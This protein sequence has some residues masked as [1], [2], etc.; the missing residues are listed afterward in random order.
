MPLADIITWTFAAIAVVAFGFVVRNYTKGLAGSPRELWLLYAYKLTETT[1]YALALPTLILSLKKDSG[2]GDMSASNYMFAYSI[3]ISVFSIGMGAFTDTV[4]I[5]KMTLAS[6][7][8][9]FIARLSLGTIDNPWVLFVMAYLPM[10]IGMAVVAPV[11]SVGVKKFTTKESSSLGF[12]LYYIIMNLGF[13]IGGWLF[14]KMRTVLGERDAAGKMVN[15]NA[16]LDLFGTHFST[17]KI[18]FLASIV[19]T[20]LSLFT[21]LA[22]RH[23]V[24]GGTLNEKPADD[25][26]G[27]ASVKGAFLATW[28]KLYT[29]ARERYFWIFVGLVGIILF[30]QAVNRH[31]SLTFPDYGIRVLGE[32]A[33]IGSVYGVLNP[34]LIIFLVPVVA[35]LTKKVPSYRLITIGSIVS[36]VACFLAAIPGH[37]F[38][39]LTHTTLGEIVFVNW[40]GLAPD[41][42]ALAANPPSPVYWP[43][44]LFITI[45]TI[46]EAIWSPRFYQFTAE[47]A[48][49]GKEATYLSLAVLPTFA[50]KFIVAAMSGVLLNTYVPVDA[51]KKVLPHDNHFMVWVWIGVSAAVTPIGLLLC[52]KR[53]HSETDRARREGAAV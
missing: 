36:T 9:L 48:P 52:S 43:L 44:M 15:E 28:D 24:A 26:E 25:G 8:A 45:F 12:A 22:M 47:I 3:I 6:I 46:G 49:K 17:Y 37:C 19:G 23:S 14:D 41:A 51:A 21:I 18:I 35:A 40:L 27:D 10:A 39:G 5:R 32:G 29:A 50:S 11:V 20:V 2:L 31:F 16:G 7:G 53:F 4:G 30:V 34:V 1:A 42:A 38:E 33:M 13:A